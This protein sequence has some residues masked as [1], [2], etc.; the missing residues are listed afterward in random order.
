[1]DDKGSIPVDGV[2]GES[3]AT[4]IFD[5]G[6]AAVMS[7]VLPGESDA[8]KTDVGLQAPV[9]W[10]RNFIQCCVSYFLMNFAF[11]L[12]MP[13]MP[14]YLVEQLGVDAS[15]VGMVLSSY[16]IG[17]LCVR[18]LSGYIVDCFSRKRLYLLSFAAFLQS[19]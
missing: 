9:L 4:E 19:H 2:S 1:M 7:G 17:L 13:S 6:A 5:A 12:L 16:T 15:R 10:N 3:S 14:L 18:P 8:V 11:Y